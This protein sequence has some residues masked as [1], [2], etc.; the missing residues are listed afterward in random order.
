M[1][2]LSKAQRDMLARNGQH[3]AIYGDDDLKP[4]VKLFTPDGN[5]TW[6]LVAIEPDFPDIAYGLCD[7]G[8]GTPE[9]GSVSL[10]EIA[11][12]RGILGLPVER[13]LHWVANR[14]LSEYADKAQ[15]DGWIR[16]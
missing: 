1:K 11:N 3:I 6:L 8:L 13:D 9:I 7:L 12:V 4:V 15:S 14:T 2:L 5:C 10:T 16:S